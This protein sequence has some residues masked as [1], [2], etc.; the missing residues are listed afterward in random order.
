MIIKIQSISGVITNSSSEVF[1]T[2]IG[3]DIKYIYE[4]LQPLFTGN[5]IDLYPYVYYNEEEQNVEVSLPYEFTNACNFYRAG[6]EAILDSQCS[7]NHYKIKY[8]Y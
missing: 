1:C 8:E 3:D 4:I 5:D 7:C 2:I 6:L